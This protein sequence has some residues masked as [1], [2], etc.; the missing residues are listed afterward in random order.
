[1]VDPVRA[2]ER[3]SLWSRGK[4]VNLALAAEDAKDAKEIKG[5]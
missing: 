4:V 3:A 1:M 5:E 2:A